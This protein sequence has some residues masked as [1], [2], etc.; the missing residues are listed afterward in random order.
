VY[1]LFGVGKG[2]GR[3][4]FLSAGSIAGVEPDAGLDLMTPRS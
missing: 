4:R 3:E 1:L 2:R